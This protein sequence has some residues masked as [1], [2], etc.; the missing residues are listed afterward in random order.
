MAGTIRSHVDTVRVQEMAQRFVGDGDPDEQTTE[1]VEWQLPPN[2]PCDGCGTSTGGVDH[3]VGPNNVSVLQA[4]RHTLVSDPDPSNRAT[5]QH[6]C[7]TATRSLY[8]R[9]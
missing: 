7:S 9:S 1:H 8:E 2:H 5:D 6:H 4:Q 3:G